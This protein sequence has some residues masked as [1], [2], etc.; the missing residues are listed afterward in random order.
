L[1]FFTI[2]G[3]ALS[4]INNDFPTLFPENTNHAHNTIS[5]MGQIQKTRLNQNTQSSIKHPST[6]L[7]CIVLLR[8]TEAH[9]FLIRIKI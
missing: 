1:A 4:S 2:Q 7:L 3:S 5:G 6:V 9:T 8:I